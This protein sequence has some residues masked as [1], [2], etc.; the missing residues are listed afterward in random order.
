VVAASFGGSWS[1][2]I[3][4][5]LS[6]AGFIFFFTEPRFSFRI[7]REEQI[8]TAVIFVIVALL[9]G[10]L[11]ARTVDQG[12]RAARAE[13]DARLL[14]F[15]PT[16]LL[17]G[18]P[19]QHIL[20]DFAR[21]LLEAL[22]LIRCEV[23]AAFD[24]QEL[25]GLAEDPHDAPGPEEVFPIV[26]GGASLGRIAAVGRNGMRSFPPEQAGLLTAAAK[27]AGLAI[28]R[29]MLDARV[30]GARME[31]ETNELRAALF[32]SVTHDLKTPLASIKFGVTSL[33][34][35][36]DVL[37][38]EQQTELLQTVTEETDRLDRLVENILELARSRAGALVL[39]R[40]KVGIDELLD[41]MLTRMR[42]RSRH[43]EIR[44]LIR[45]DVPDLWID[46]V[47]MDQALTNVLENALAH[48]PPRG[49]IDI[50]V[51]RYRSTVEVRIVDHGP[52][53]PPED[54]E[55]VFEPFF[56]GKKAPERAGSGLGLTIAHA[57]VVTHGGGIRVET[58]AGGGT[59]VIISLPIEGGV[60][61]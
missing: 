57:I 6:A 22:G 17:S 47:Q 40:R 61:S 21:A 34:T 11:F 15:L 9:V 20:D 53:I 55:R 54:R 42:A 56:R 37:D 46:P 33:L 25:K 12:Q 50:S 1:G 59:A 4:A 18:K 7:D 16:M 5:V 43:V 38:P 23:V 58:A 41:A 35:D 60:T 30:R 28:E 32:S 2:L 52:G 24:D 49:L 51:A 8:V 31:A 3:T 29:T 36:R 45:P 44:S 39:E 13:R 10:A 14:S 26:A 27:Q 19:L 48:S